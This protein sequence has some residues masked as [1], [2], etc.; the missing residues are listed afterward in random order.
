MSC[1]VISTRGLAIAPPD[2][3]ESK[4]TVDR[5]SKIKYLQGLKSYRFL[6][7]IIQYLKPIF[8]QHCSE[9]TQELFS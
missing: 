4:Q 5:L 2:N 7:A 9:I 1:I 8:Q 3:P 6:Q